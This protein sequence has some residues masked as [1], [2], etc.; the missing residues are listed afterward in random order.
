MV[1]LWGG[2]FSCE[3]GNPVPL[4]REKRMTE[5]GFKLFY[6]KVETGFWSWL[7]RMLQGQIQNP[8]P[9]TF[10]AIRCRATTKG[11]MWGYPRPVLG[12]V[13][14]LLEPFRGH[15]SPNIDNVSKTLTLRYPHEGPWVDCVISSG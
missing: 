13:D 8:Q 2:A 14:P 15:L 1:I 6:L 12:A 5:R 3:R 10:S 4:P 11:P 7:S 9:P